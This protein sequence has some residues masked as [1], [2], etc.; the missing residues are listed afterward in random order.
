MIEKEKLVEY[1]NLQENTYL[2]LYIQ[3]ICNN[4]E[5]RQK[6]F[7]TQ[8]HHIIPKYYFR[9]N[10][11]F[12]DNSCDNVVNLTYSDHILAHIYLGLCCKDKRDRY[13]NFCAINKLLGEKYLQKIN[14]KQLLHDISKNVDNY[15]DLYADYLSYNSEK[16]RKH[17]ESLS[18]EEKKL[19]NEKR[20]STIATLKTVHKDNYEIRV[21]EDQLNIYLEQ[22]FILGRSEINRIKM[23]EAKKGSTP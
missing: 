12:I 4:K 10:N 13:S 6:R 17:H 2:D 1:L 19:I 5:T 8:K 22:G 9:R 11:K 14:L 3:L 7:L 18:E 15:N 21:P 16:S 23:S 20:I